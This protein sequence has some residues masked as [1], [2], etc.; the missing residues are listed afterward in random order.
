[1]I[2][3]SG[4]GTPDPTRTLEVYPENSL[5]Y[6]IVTQNTYSE[7]TITLTNS[8]TAALSISDIGISGN[9][10]NQFNVVNP[11]SSSF[12]IPSNGT[13]EVVVRFTPNSQGGKTASLII[14]NN[15]DNESPQKVISLSGT[16]KVNTILT[17]I[18]DVTPSD[19]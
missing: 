1:M 18:R 2:S 6:G 15:S 19:S 9:D 12:E 16:G 7:K 5:E 3:L 14:G 17:K 11:S 8:G 10:A 13:M 4:T